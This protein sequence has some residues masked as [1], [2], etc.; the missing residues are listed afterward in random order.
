MNVA[1]E[2]SDA[3]LNMLFLSSVQRSLSGWTVWR[4]WH[5]ATEIHWS[6]YDWP[7]NVVLTSE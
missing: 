7:G 1:Q 4:V 6:C 2:R 5:D 3:D